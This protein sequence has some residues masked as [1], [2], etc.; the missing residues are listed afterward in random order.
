MQELHDYI[1]YYNNIRM[2]SKLKDQSPV[3]YRSKVQQ[4]A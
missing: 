4:V 1:Y 2:K 3:E